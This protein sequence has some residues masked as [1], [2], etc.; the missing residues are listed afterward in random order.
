MNAYME[1]QRGDQR[2]HAGYHPM[3][4]ERRQRIVQ[5][6]ATL[7]LSYVKVP[8]YA[9]LFERCFLSSV[10]YNTSLQWLLNAHFSVLILRGRIWSELK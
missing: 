2:S 9:G 1:S 4:I 7:T 5:W 6:P 10:V 3:S 8:F